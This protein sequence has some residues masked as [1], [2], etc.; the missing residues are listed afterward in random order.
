MARIFISHSS[1]DNAKAMA[2][3]EW[4]S[5]QGWDDVFLDLDPNRGL[6]AG[7]RWQDALK[8]ASGA[9]ELVI[10]LISPAWARSQWCLAEF[11]LA[12]QLNKRIF[13]AFIEPTPL[14]MLPLELTGEWQLVDLTAGPTGFERALAPTPGAEPVQVSLAAD[15]LERLRIGL[16]QAGLDA[17]YFVWPPE[18]DPKRPPFRGLKP[19]EAEDAGI[20]FGRDASIIKA[21]D[22]LRGLSEAV[23]PRLMVILGSS[24]AGKSSFMRAGL[25]PRLARD[26]RRYRLLPIIRPNLAVVSGNDGLASALEIALQS[27]GQ[28]PTRAAVEEAIA[29]GA[30]AVAELLRPFAEM[31]QDEGEP[32]LLI[33]PIDQGEELFTANEM[34][35]VNEFLSLLGALLKLER[36]AIAML[37]TIRSDSYEALQAAPALEEIRQET[38][39]LPPM[40]RGSFGQV[41]T[42][43]AARLAATEQPLAIEDALTEMLLADI[44]SGG[45]KDALPLL[46]FTLER[47]YRSY[48]GNGNLKLAEYESQGGIGGAIEAAVDQALKAADA[49]P[50]IPQDKQARL[51]LLRRGL[52]PWLAGIDPETGAPQRR[53]ARRSE[54]PVE[55][56]ALINLL[57]EQRLLAIDVSEEAGDVTIEPAHEAILRQWSLLEDWL[58]SDFEDLSIAE[59]MKRAARDWLANN[60]DAEWLAHTGGRLEVAE[61]VVA[62]ADFHDLFNPNERAYLA[63]ARKVDNVRRH[64][65]DN[66]LLAAEGARIDLKRFRQRKR[67]A[68]FSGLV[69]ASIVSCLV[70]LGPSLTLNLMGDHL[71]RLWP[72]ERTSEPVVLVYVD[73]T[74]LEE[75]GQWPVPRQRMAEVIRAVASAQ[76]AAIIVDVLFVDPEANSPQSLLNRESVPRAARD[77]L[78]SLQGGDEALAEAISAGP[79]VLSLGGI[80]GLDAELSPRGLTPFTQVRARNG[81]PGR[82]VRQSIR[83]F[84]PL[85]NRPEFRAAASGEGGI[86]LADR[87]AVKLRTSHQL[88]DIGKDVLIPGLAVEALRV[89]AGADGIRTVTDVGGVRHLDLMHGSNFLFRID[90]EWD[91]AIRPWFS[92]R[93]VT[94]EATALNVLLNASER[95]RLEGK[96]VIIGVNVDATNERLTPLNEV[97]PGSEI[98]KQT[99]ECVFEGNCVRRPFWIRVAE[100]IAAIVLAI[101]L[102]LWWLGDRTGWAAWLTGL[103]PFTP[104]ALAFMFYAF[105]P[106]LLDGLAVAIVLLAA[107]LPGIFVQVGSKRRDVMPANTS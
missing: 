33:L 50:S 10:F 67:A 20:F 79:V 1:R 55:A 12:K 21:L 41:I 15:G 87:F 58:E 86:V 102:A 40:P 56:R 82:F 105:G 16:Q 14:D 85:Y 35:E 31:P 101:V 46:A 106:Y 49:D 11:L 23:Q 93:D 17:S 18:D 25:L 27:A 89:A 52:I 62:R 76:P 26:R 100:P 94:Q 61:R 37:I 39:S 36:P 57:I 59:G 81:D 84:V 29:K 28:R 64:E 48:G 47:L 80:K 8:R 19:F 5:T 96:L 45:G 9:C 65:A 78:Q 24:G 92:K 53:I 3:H 69:L 6:K 7:E 30:T 66:R 99:L 54:I 88:Y 13:G 34:E 70:Y 2:F 60:E 38:F 103:I 72:R 91:G 75:F 42:G 77:W 104:F 51:A 32:P 4:L 22:M 83:P 68:F 44:E 90:T 97:V 98:Y 73:Q 107:S 71:N 95:S 74:S 43:P 63:A